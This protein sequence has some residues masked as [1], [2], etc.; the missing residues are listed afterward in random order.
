MATKIDNDR[1]FFEGLMQRDFLNKEKRFALKA[2]HIRMGMRYYREDMFTFPVMTEEEREV[3][4][5]KLFELCCHFATTAKESG[6]ENIYHF[7]P[8]Y[9]NQF[10]TPKFFDLVPNEWFTQEFGF[11][12]ACKHYKGMKKGHH[13]LLHS[14]RRRKIIGLFGKCNKHKGVRFDKDQANLFKYNNNVM[15][16]YRCKGW[17]P[18][19]FFSQVIRY[20][21]YKILIDEDSNYTIDDF[22]EEQNQINICSFLSGSD[23]FY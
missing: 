4:Q 21:L 5:E 1:E 8:K 18:S 2:D 3:R 12:F 19:K 7:W 20:R 11:C 17:E 10:M 14:I 6:H 22:N 23:T 15:P 16:N 13:K 9:L